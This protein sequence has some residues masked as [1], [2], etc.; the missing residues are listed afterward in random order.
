MIKQYKNKIPVK[1][2]TFTGTFKLDCMFTHWY[3]WLTFYVIFTYFKIVKTIH[4]TQQYIQGCVL[5][6]LTGV[7][8]VGDWPK[9]CWTYLV[10]FG[11]CLL[12]QRHLTSLCLTSVGTLHNWELN[13]DATR[14][15]SRI[16]LRNKRK[17]IYLFSVKSSN[18]LPGPWK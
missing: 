17:I 12:C 6:L 4:S 3:A 11:L 14:K 9:P 10:R 13:L 18:M 8:Q 16:V 2:S 5:T 1:T 7:A 15:N